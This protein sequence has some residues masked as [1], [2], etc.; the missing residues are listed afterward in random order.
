MEPQ[1]YPF[2]I[3]AL[4]KR[5]YRLFP[6]TL[7][8]DYRVFFHA[9]AAE[10]LNSILEEGLR[11][12]VEV[13]KKLTTISYASNS[14]IALDHWITIRGRGQDGVIL[15]LQ[16]ESLEEI[17]VDAGTHYSRA[18]KIQPAIVGKCTVPSNYDHR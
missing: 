6:D 12:G 10:K 14:M 17:F 16:F 5:G 9:T 8:N 13:G 18:L 1:C 11:P 3:E 2:P 4:A 15:A 7:E